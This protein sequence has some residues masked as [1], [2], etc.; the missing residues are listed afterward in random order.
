MKKYWYSDL[1]I[2]MLHRRISK[3]RLFSIQI[4]GYGINQREAFDKA[5]EI[6]KKYLKG[7]NENI[8]EEN[9]IKWNSM[10]GFGK[11]ETEYIDYAE[12]LDILYQ[13]K[14]KL[15]S[16]I[17]VSI[18]V[19]DDDWN[20]IKELELMSYESY[21]KHVEKRFLKYKIKQLKNEV[22]KLINEYERMM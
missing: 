19:V 1:G 2:G 18:T 22:N 11:Y 12:L 8:D 17:L 16:D 5:I 13:S 4:Y 15:N 6:K 10:N 9:F 7:Y 21:I 3:N 20:T 14:Y